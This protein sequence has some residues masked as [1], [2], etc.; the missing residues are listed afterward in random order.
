MKEKIQ[1]KDEAL[2]L[3]DNLKIKVKVNKLKDRINLNEIIKAELEEIDD[4]LYN[5]LREEIAIRVENQEMHYEIITNPIMDFCMLVLGGSIYALVESLMKDIH[6]I[7]FIE[8]LGDCLERIGHIWMNIIILYVIA[9]IFLCGRM[10]IRWN[11]YYNDRY[12]YKI[13]LILLDKEIVSKLKLNISN[14]RN[15]ENLGSSSNEK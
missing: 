3:I 1:T 5:D 10:W 14:G 15:L 8:R 9:L 7:V 6:R 13:L 12:T 11:K 2:N 4:K